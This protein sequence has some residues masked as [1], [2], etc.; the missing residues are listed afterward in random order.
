MATVESTTTA[1]QLIYP[2]NR[3]I[4][5]QALTGYLFYIS[6]GA[7]N[8]QV[9]RSTNNGATWA[10]F[11]P[12][13]NVGVTIAEVGSFQIDSWNRIY[14]PIRANV[15]SQDRVYM[16]AGVLTTTYIYWHTLTQ[17][18]A[19]ANGGVSGSAISGMSTT[20]IRHK[21]ERTV[22]FVAA[23][24]VSGANIG[25]TLYGFTI[26]ALGQPSLN[27]AVIANFR[28]WSIVGSGR[29][30]PASGHEAGSGPGHAW[31]SFGRTHMYGIKLTW[32][33]NGWTGPRAPIK[34]TA[35]T[36]TPPALDSVAAVWRY[37]GWC[38]AQPHPDDTTTVL[39]M[40]RNQANTLTTYRTTP[41][42]PTGVVR[43][44]AIA[45]NQV[46]RDVRVWAVG[47]STDV[48]YHIDY[49]QATGLWTAWT[50]SV[51][52]PITGANNYNVRIDN[53][54][55]ANYDVLTMSGAASPWTVTH[56]AQK[57]SY[58]PFAPAWNIAPTGYTNGG[59]ADVSAT[60]P[61]TWIFSDADAADVQS[62]WALSRQIG[63]GTLA[64]FRAS[65]STWQSTEQKNAGASSTVTLAAGWGADTDAAYTYK[66]KVWDS[67]DLASVYSQA[68]VLIPSV[69]ANPSLIVA[70]AADI[71]PGLD[72]GFEIGTT[73]WIASN[74]TLTRSTAQA[75]TGTASGRLLTNAA[76]NPKVTRNA[77]D[78]ATAGV[79]YTL[80]GWLYA[81]A[82]LGASQA[83]ASLEWWNGAAFVSENVALVTMPVG[84][85]THV[86]I[87]AT[88]PGGAN[89]VRRS[90]GISGAVAA[91]LV[92]HVDD[93]TILAPVGG[94]I[95]TDT[96]IASWIVTEQTAYRVT[97]STFPDGVVVYDTGW[98]G[99]TIPDTSHVIAYPL[100]D[101]TTWT[102][103]LQTRN[104]E[105]LAST[106]QTA[107]F[108]V[109][110]SEPP[111]PTCRLTPMPDS[112]IIRVAVATP[113]PTGTQP[114]VS[115]QTVYRRPRL[116][117]NLLP[118]PGFE[119]GSGGSGWFV[120]DGT[121]ARSTAQAHT[122]TW[123]FFVTPDGV[124]FFPRVDGAYTP[125]TGVVRAGGWI[126]AAAGTSPLQIAI[127]AFDAAG[128]YL[129]T[130]GHRRAT[131]AIGQWVYLET[132]ADFGDWSTAALCT[133]ALGRGDGG[134]TAPPAS[135]TF[136][137]DDGWVSPDDPDDGVVIASGLLDRLGVQ[138]AIVADTFT[139]TATAGWGIPEVGGG[140]PW[141]ASGGS[142]ADFSVDGSVG[143]VSLGVVNDPYRTVV[144]IASAPLAVEDFEDQYFAV[145]IAGTWGRSQV[146]AQSGTW[147]MKAPVTA[148]S[149]TA[150][151]VVAL[152]SG[153]TS[154]SFY[155]WVSSEPVSD[156]FRVVSHTGTTLFFDSGV[157][158]SW[159]F[160]K[161]TV[162]AGAPSV[163]FRY[164]KDPSVSAGED[165]VFVDQ[166][167]CLD[168]TG[169]RD[170]DIVTS[171]TVPVVPTGASINVG[172]LARYTDTSNFYL[173]EMLVNAGSTITARI[174]KSVAGSFTTVQTSGTIAGLVP[175]A[176]KTYRLRFVCQGSTLRVRIWDPALSE[177][178]VWHLDL[179]DTS[180]TPL[181][182]QVGIRS[183]IG[184]GNTNTLPIVLSFDSFL[185]AGSL[186]SGTKAAVV[187]DW[188]AAS[189]IDYEYRVLAQGVNG[190]SAYGPWTA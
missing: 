140:T 18:A 137:V 71:N 138:T 115:E 93:G 172:L 125:L 175:A 54:Q 76:T 107:G 171:V 184:V 32:N 155:Y 114:A 94:T 187:D 167:T 55:S 47:T 170:A 117:T 91:G 53:Y 152:P 1:N 162:P 145:P 15:T 84:V 185:V 70:T 135:D 68:L 144:S 38:V 131:A 30:T 129:A 190:T 105:G 82:S 97:L 12:V 168:D 183:A 104:N 17:L 79:Q 5:R 35:S 78:P 24:F 89:G 189:G 52:T 154:V 41:A 124:G 31:V 61:L 83:F 36:T 127:H 134:I 66:V 157:A 165:T 23:A 2:G 72:T 143:K 121:G 111:T 103:G 85:W 63:T 44:C 174:R 123:S 39:M 40:E 188:R 142:A 10:A 151:M 158:S 99:G 51:A 119:I 130:R 9:Y 74:G 8:I 149:G 69:K 13:R 87:A 90:F 92:L 173:G 118:D 43:S 19:V 29:Q 126:R 166:L 11:G 4:S 160:A 180:L 128:G 59:A 156:F 136:Y 98:Q 56:T 150:D 178:T 73:G 46:S 42:H 27:N 6:Y 148:H 110:Y 26:G 80:D 182:S 120:L 133:V 34:L 77:N 21:D 3:R 86:S 177:P 64:Y 60:L 28:S 81:P 16:Q 62:A 102:V 88:C 33:G 45:F 146:R 101:G 25:V 7:T 108:F 161:V 147:S 109:D 181:T 186:G 58:A 132:T 106:L 176:G 169:G 96:V 75:H 50:I 22:G 37:P 116:Y 179:T 164:I 122:D 48:L 163:T 112:G 139:R 141:L 100:P 14:I 20:A 159:Q 95:T 49:V 67:V 113:A 153:T 65:D 57:Q